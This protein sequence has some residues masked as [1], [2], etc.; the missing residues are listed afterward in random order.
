MDQ[1]NADV[2]YAATY[3]R[4][5]AVYGFNGGG[6]GS[7]VWKSVDAGKTWAY[8]SAARA[9]RQRAWYYTVLTIDPR[10]PDIVWFPQVNLLRTV[11]ALPAAYGVALVAA[12]T[13]EIAEAALKLIEVEYEPL[14]F[15]S[16]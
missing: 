15:V 11:D 10:N 1:R 16:E 12:A 13:K 9:L 3:Q 7:A 5:R 4:L 6:P 8:V 2:L 14:T